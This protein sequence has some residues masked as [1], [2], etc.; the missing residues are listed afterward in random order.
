[1]TDRHEIERA[2]AEAGDNHVNFMSEAIEA[3]KNFREDYEG[4]MNIVKHDQMLF[5]RSPDGLI[6]HIIHEKMNTKE[7]CIEMYMQFIEAGK[8]TGKQRHL[9]EEI[10]FVVEGSGYDLHWDVR[11]DCGDKF[12]WEW[13]K[14]PKKFEWKEG[15]FVYIPPYCMHQRFNANGEQTARI[16]VCNS[17]MVRPMGFDWFEQ[18][19]NAEGF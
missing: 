6:K 17:S 19:E 11:F 8:A 15:D 13:E 14:E 1:M 10:A 5:E 7:C 2:R 12:T 16:I 4:R 3:S 9:S 18:V